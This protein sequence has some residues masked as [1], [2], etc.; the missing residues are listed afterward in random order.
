MGVPQ[1]VSNEGTIFLDFFRSGAVGHPCGLDNRG[2]VSHIVNQA[3]ES[4]IENRKTAPQDFVK[5]RDV[6]TQYQFLL[7]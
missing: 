2:I 1:Q 3:N 6:G 7:R 4:V 5:C